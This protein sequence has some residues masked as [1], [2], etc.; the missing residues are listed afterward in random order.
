MKKRAYLLLSACLFLSALI[1]QKTTHQVN[2]SGNAYVVEDRSGAT[3][4]D[5]GLIKWTSSASIINTYIYFSKAQTVSVSLK[6]SVAQG[7]ST[8]QLTA[9]NQQS[10]IK[11]SEGNFEQS[12]GNFIVSEEG[13]VPFSL[14]GVSKSGAEFATIQSLLI[15]SV[16]E[17]LV[18]VHDFSDYWGRRGPSVH[19]NFKMPTDTIEWFY[20]EVTVPEHNDVLA[21]YYMANGFGEGYFGMQANSPTERRILFSVWSPY[22][23][24]DPKLIPDSLKIKMLRRGEGVHIGEFGNEGSGGQSY[25]RYNWKAGITYKFLTQ[26]KPTGDGSSIYTSYF[27]ATDEGRWRLIASFLRPEIDTYYTRAHSFLEN[28]DPQQG[29]LTR[30]V[31]FGNQWYRTKS[32]QWIAGYKS[33]F[34]HDATASKGV[35]VDYK[36]GYNQNKNKFYLQNCGFFHDSTPFG[37]PFL[38]TPAT[39]APEIDFEELERLGE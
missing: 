25:L 1:A 10:T 14:Q 35:R 30:K 26:I 17:E 13:Y 27:Y 23:T 2:L 6:G 34:S 39:D 11:L 7:N 24:Q 28:F 8:V 12:V 18:Y 33:T 38:L 9:N 29:Y 31:Y 15:T 19:L 16:D 4:S 21:S 36:G 37:T 3:I 5:R 20:N 32:G 22:D